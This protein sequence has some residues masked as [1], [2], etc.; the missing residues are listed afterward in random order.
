MS[1]VA[2]HI[3]QLTQQVQL[4]RQSQDNSYKA[5]S[6]ELQG[7]KKSIQFII[8]ENQDKYLTTRQAAEKLGVSSDYIKKLIYKDKF[9]NAIQ[10]TG[11]RG[12]YRIPLSDVQAYLTKAKAI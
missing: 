6:T 7:L 8:K 10:P 2:L 11:N 4:L 9:P 5:L 3:E 1:E 12:E